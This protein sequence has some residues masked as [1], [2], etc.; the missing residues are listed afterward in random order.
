MGEIHPDVAEKYG[1]KGERVYCCEI[2]CGALERK[3]NTE[4]VYTPLP[5]FP[6][7]A[8]DIALLVDEDMEVG[9]IEAVIKEFGGRILEDVRLFDVY[10]GQQ[11]DEGKK[12]VAFSLIYRDKDKTLTDEEVNDVHSGVLDALKDKLNAVLRE[13]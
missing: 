7:T 10:R 3:A 8:R 9:R 4:I 1:M 13:M 6:S 12:S 2:M 11:V 5:K